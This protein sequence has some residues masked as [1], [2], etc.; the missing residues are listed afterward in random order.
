MYSKCRTYPGQN[1]PKNPMS[2]QKSAQ[3]P[4]DRTSFHELKCAKIGNFQ[5]VGHFYQILHFFVK[6]YQKPYARAKF[7]SQNLMPGQKLTPEIPNAQACTSVRTF[8]WEFPLASGMP[9]CNKSVAVSDTCM[10][11]IKYLDTNK[12]DHILEHMKKSG[13]NEQKFQQQ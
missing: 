10:M 6:N 4:N 5:Q 3:K 11:K 12:T 7:T 2:G 13:S 8:I 9:F 1:F